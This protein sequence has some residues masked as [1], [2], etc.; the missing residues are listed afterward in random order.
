MTTR[1]SVLCDFDGTISLQDTTDALLER[2]G[3][4]GWR[5]LEQRWR[6]GE[7]GS[8]E[9]MAGQIELLQMTRSELDAHLD[10]VAIDPAFGAFVKAASAADM[11]LM[12]VSDGLDYAVRRVLS[13][14]DLGNLPVVANQLTAV[15]D[16]RWRLGFPYGSVG[17]ASGNCKCACAD[18]AHGER[19]RVLLIGDG[20]SDFCVADDA[21]LV[22]AKGR[23]AEHCRAVGI[24]HLVIAGFA[25][26]LRELPRLRAEEFDALPQP[27]HVELPAL[28]SVAA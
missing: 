25:D 28:R 26:A 2:F 3:R 8:R 27:L 19:E 14:H 21:D 1:W 13:R 16:D 20:T 5:E 9:C 22:L 12:V 4:P 6:L 10:A 7:I 15:G 23:L 17:C 24:P 18:R 11:R